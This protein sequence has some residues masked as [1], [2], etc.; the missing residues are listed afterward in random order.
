MTTHGTW[1]VDTAQRPGEG[2]DAM[3]SRWEWGC[4]TTQKEGHAARGDGSEQ[5]QNDKNKKLTRVVTGASMQPEEVQWVKASTNRDAALDG[6]MQ[7]VQVSERRKTTEKK[8]CTY[9]CM[10]GA[11]EREQRTGVAL[12][13]EHQQGKQC[14]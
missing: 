10:G 2:A 5:R 9:K 1:G 14:E 11:K 13:K 7:E 6:T 4:S 12:K 3:C 8:K